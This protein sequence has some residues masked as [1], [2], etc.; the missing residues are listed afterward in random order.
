VSEINFDTKR[1]MQS[2]PELAALANVPQNPRYHGEGDVLKHTL[3][4][5]NELS[6]H[7]RW[8][9]LSSEDKQTLFLAALFHDIGKLVTTV[10]QNDTISSPK[11]S[12]WGALLTRYLLWKGIGE[13]IGFHQRERIVHLVRNHMQP[14]YLLEKQDPRR[15]LL[16]MSLVVDIELLA[17]LAECDTLGRIASDTQQGLDTIALFREY[18]KDEQC[19]AGPY[20]FPSNHTKYFY[21]S[22][23]D[24]SPEVDYYDDR[25]FEV[26]M[27]SG[28]PASG[29]DHWIT[30]HGKGLPVISL[31]TIR[32]EMKIG[33]TDNQ[34]IVVQTAKE[35]AKRLLASKQPFIWNAVNRLRSIRQ[36]LIAMCNDYGARVRIIYL[37][38]DYRTHLERNSRRT[39]PV[40]EAV[41]DKMAKRNE[42][43][44]PYEAHEVE[45]R[46]GNPS[47][48]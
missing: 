27:L 16:R 40:P 21:F 23:E 44:E 3:M 19:L 20:P 1:Y 13:P 10:Q 7:P 11:H 38:S 33:A 18:V 45:Y 35:R 28:L 37:E 47:L 43:P 12:V 4:V 2:V 29:K 8:P 39:S 25:T 26:I 14:L 22:K 5:V 30:H 15:L 42:I 32:S 34:G 31:D 41:I 48:S 9:T 17:I 36:P 24:T 46:I 6:H